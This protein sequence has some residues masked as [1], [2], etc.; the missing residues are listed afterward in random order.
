MSRL[1]ECSVAGSSGDSADHGGQKGMVRRVKLAEG[2]IRWV[3][4]GYGGIGSGT[5][6]LL[7]GR[8]S[9]AMIGLVFFHLWSSWR[10]QLLQAFLSAPRSVVVALT[11]LVVVTH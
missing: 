6:V 7:T 2:D 11:R 1:G 9:D 3:T 5:M 4:P 10:V 8:V